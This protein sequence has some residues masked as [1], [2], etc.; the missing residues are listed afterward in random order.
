MNGTANH[1]LLP[2]R[3]STDT[4][5]P[6]GRVLEKLEAS[7][8]LL[9]IHQVLGNSPNAFRPFMQMSDAL[10]TRAA[11]PHDIREIVILWLAQD[12]GVPYEWTEHV[13]MARRAGVTKEDI[14]AIERGDQPA[15]EE[16]RLGVEIARSLVSGAGVSADAW[17]RGVSTWT[18]EGMLDLV[19][20]VGWWGG[21][22]PIAIEALGL[23]A[24]DVR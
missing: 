19:F 3:T 1:R 9:T 4:E 12:R 7:G 13:P 24:A 2:R 16:A 20:T 8:Y 6:S 15:A 21:F 14:S 17:A 22:V 11:L 23:D 5:G 18:A 10:F